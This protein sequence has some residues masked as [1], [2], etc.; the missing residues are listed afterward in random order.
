MANKLVWLRKLVHAK[1]M[2][3]YMH[4]TKRLAAYKKSRRQRLED[5]LG[6]IYFIL[7]AI[8]FCVLSLQCQ[9]CI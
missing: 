8:G 1:E 4:E 7:H 2:Y 5:H 6:I 9:H 3:K